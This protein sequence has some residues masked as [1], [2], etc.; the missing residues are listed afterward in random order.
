MEKPKAIADREKC[1]SCGGC[2]SVCPKDAIR[3]CSNK[4]FVSS[5][6]CIGCGICV[7][8]CPI[9]AISSEADT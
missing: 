9:G 4:A 6:K 3:M 7:K 8:I 1:L 2:I 5:E